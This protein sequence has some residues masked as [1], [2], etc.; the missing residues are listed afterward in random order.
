MYKAVRRALRWTDPRTSIG[1]PLMQVRQSGF[2]YIG[3]LIAVMLMGIM[4]SAAATLWS[5]S[6]QREREAELLFIG[7]QYRQAIAAYYAAGGTGFQYPRELQDLLEDNRAP[8][9]RRF[10]RQL[11]RDPMTGQAD[12]QLIRT[13][14]GGILGIVSNSHA[15][16]IKRSNF[17]DV[18]SAFELTECYCDWQFVYQPRRGHPL[19]TQ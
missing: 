1:N 14:D 19:R 5:F 13:N 12:W 18:D 15:K 10:L 6:A 16:P 11:Y 2:T 7:H 3:L 8:S 9:P 17:R 4:S